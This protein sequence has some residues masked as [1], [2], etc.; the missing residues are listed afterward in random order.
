MKPRTVLV[1]GA[2]SGL[3]RAMALELAAQGAY[4]AL[5]ARRLPLLEELAQEIRARGGHAVPLALDVQDAAAVADTVKRAERELGSLD[6]IVANA[7]VGSAGHASTLT[8]ASVD[9]VLA[10]N[11]RGA[12]ATLLAGV[13]IMLAQQRGHLVAISSLAGRRGLPG[14][15]A[16]GASKAAL[17]SFMETL[18]LDL[19]H[20]GIHVTDVQPGFIATPMNENTPHPTPFK[21]PVERAAR[22]IVRR[23]AKNPAVISFPWPLDLLTSFARLLPTWAYGP[24]LR[25]TQGR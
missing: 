18:R 9:E 12:L 10:V 22:T 24:L 7:G 15:G 6:M 1:T 5:T 21:W 3:G 16:Y 11:V 8:W 2:S 25:S 4:V 23:L 17:S 14:S 13:P 19:A 20:A